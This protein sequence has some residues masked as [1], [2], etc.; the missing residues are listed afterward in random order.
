MSFFLLF[1]PTGFDVSRHLVESF[2]FFLFFDE[3]D[4][5]GDCGQEE[6]SGE[7]V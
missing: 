6:H 2:L 5:D 7:S 1:E 4:G 3:E